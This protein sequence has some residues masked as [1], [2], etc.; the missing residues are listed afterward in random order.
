MTRITTYAAFFPHY[1]REHSL[2]LTRALHYGGTA[3]STAAIIAG[4]A[5]ALPYWPLVALIAGYGPAW[6]GHFFIEK[7]RPAT[8]TYP[9]WSLISDYRMFGLWISG[10]LG[11]ALAAAHAKEAFQD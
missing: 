1:L 2:P 6:V 4:L 8:F 3:G 10:R 9:F 7:N 5:G 11:P